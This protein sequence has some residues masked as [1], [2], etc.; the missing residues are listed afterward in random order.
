[1]ANGEDPVLR[2]A[3]DDV[4]ADRRRGSG[5]TLSDAEWLLDAYDRVA[6]TDPHGVGRLAVSYRTTL[7]RLRRPPTRDEIGELIRRL[8]NEDVSTLSTLQEFWV[9]RIRRGD[10]I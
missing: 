2:A 8:T 5:L 6:V 7:V 4:I 3:F 1:V 9:A 10:P